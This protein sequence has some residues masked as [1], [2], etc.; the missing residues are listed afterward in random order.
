MA[1]QTIEFCR[2]VDLPELFA[3]FADWCRFNPRLQERDY[4]DWQ[5]K[6]T[7]TRISSDEYDFLILRDGGRIRGCLGFTGFEL[8]LHGRIGGWTQNWYADGQRDGGLAVLLRFME[9]VDNR[10]IIRFN[11]NTARVLSLL[12]VP[13]IPLLPRWWAAL[14][15]P[16]CLSFFQ[17]DGRDGDVVVRSAA[18]MKELGETSDARE[19]SRFDDADHFSLAH[20][21]SDICHA[22][23]S[24]RYLNWRYF[25]IPRHT[26]RAVRSADQFTIFRIE[27]VKGASVSVI[28]IL[29]WTFDANQSRGALAL[30]V[31]AATGLNPIM[32]DFH[33]TC[34]PIGDCLEALGFVQQSATV[35]PMPDLFRPTNYSGGVALAIDLPPHR[36]ARKVNFSD[37]Y[38]TI[39]DGDV[40]RIKL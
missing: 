23:R 26:Y 8:N 28:R 25:D 39:G 9:L 29:E 13:M 10:F 31:N 34:E 19:I 37:W 33:C 3:C 11:D 5:F 6:Y 1:S 12:R 30:I 17:F 4:F 35:K 38:I 24:G 20:F 15:A 40:D 7:P 21:G 22:M 18:A 27:P 14:D 32:I 16:A 36:T 2:E